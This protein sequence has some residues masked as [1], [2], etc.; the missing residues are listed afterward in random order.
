MNFR[1]RSFHCHAFR[2]VSRL[3]G[4]IASEQSRVISEH[5]SGKRLHKG[6]G[7]SNI[8]SRKMN[9]EYWIIIWSNA[10]HVA[11]AA[12]QFHGAREDVG[13]SFIA[14]RVNHTRCVW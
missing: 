9:V 1:Q 10:D 14:R 12:L 8:G 11:S 4:I 5:L 13:S 6:R 7:V 3:V 2:E